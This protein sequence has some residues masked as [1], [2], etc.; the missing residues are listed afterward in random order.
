MKLLLRLLRFVIVFSLAWFL[1]S[2][3]R[4]SEKDNFEKANISIRRFEQ[5]LFSLS[6]YHLEDSI[7]YLRREYPDFFPL[8]CSKVIEIGDP[9]DPEFISGLKAFVTDFTIF[10]VSRRVA[11]VF[12][13]LRTFEND[14]GNAFGRYESFFPEK[15]VPAILTCISGFN[16]SI[17]TFEGHLVISL[18][19]YLGPDDEFYKL[20][21]PPVP[22]YQRRVMRPEKIVPDALQAWLITEFPFN[23]NKYNLASNMIYQGRVLY[24]VR[25]LLPGISDTLLFGYT[26]NELDFCVDHEKSMWEY[27]VENKKLFI[28]DHFT[29]S[30]FIGEGPFTKDF[31]Q[32]SPGRAAIWQGYR[33]VDSYMRHNREVSLEQLMREN[34]YQDILNLSRYDP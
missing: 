23:D 15:P 9:D 16:Q 8:F 24:V 1:F 27:L 6:V 14:F 5:D 11:E 33:I 25:K 22:Q 32:E 10:R 29:I 12:P 30:Q 4:S 26:R 21:Y 3:T 7:E 31:S 13:D 2:C 28:T 17:I 19:K 20:M 18:D 34:D